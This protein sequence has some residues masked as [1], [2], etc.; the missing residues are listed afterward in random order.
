MFAKQ[1]TISAAL[2]AAMPAMCAAQSILSAHSG[3]LHYFEGDVRIDGA[4]VQYRPGHF[5]EI[6]EKSILSTGLGRAEVL[7]TPGVFLRIGEGSSV[8][9]LDNRLVSTRVD[10]LSGTVSVESDDPDISVK[11][12]PVTLLYK[13]YEIQLVKHGILEVGTSPAQMKVYQGDA[14][15]TNGNDRVAVKQGHLLPFTGVLGT[16]K[17]NANLVD[18]L[19]L[20]ARDRS[21]FLSSVNVATTRDLGSAFSGSNWYFNAWFGA[22]TFIPGR[23]TAWNPWGFGF[24]TPA[25]ILHYHPPANYGYGTNPAV[26]ASNGNLQHPGRPAPATNGVAPTPNAA[27]AGQRGTGS[28]NSANTTPFT[29]SPVRSGANVGAP[30][31]QPAPRPVP[32]APPPA[33][34]NNSS[35]QNT[36]TVGPTGR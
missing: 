12:S 4:P 27:F 1:L 17:F 32:V 20:W 30:A 28:A 3:T 2:L 31:P 7:L 35:S 19:T 33:P 29:A 10:I 13:N 6:K 11:D 23:G 26:N 34:A 5:D 22:F 9:V 16:E 24:Y 14:M 18:S 36:T 8:Q 15:V 25:T 21:Q